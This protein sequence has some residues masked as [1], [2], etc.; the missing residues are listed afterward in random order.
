MKK[1]SNA[2]MK[3]IMG[4]GGPTELMFDDGG[5]SAC[6][7][8][9]RVAKCYGTQQNCSGATWGTCGTDQSCHEYCVVNGEAQ[10]FC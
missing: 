4:G 6:G 10:Y 2:E 7:A 5:A 8:G 9:C 1:L 3:T